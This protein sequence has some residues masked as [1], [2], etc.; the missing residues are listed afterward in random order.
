MVRAP[1]TIKLGQ[2]F[3]SVGSDAFRVVYLCALEGRIMMMMM[4]EE[5]GPALVEM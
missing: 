3:G 2:A 4:R 5:G 1:V